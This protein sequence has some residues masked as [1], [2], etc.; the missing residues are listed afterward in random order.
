[1]LERRAARDGRLIDGLELRERA[2]A[3]HA[4]I[5]DRFTLSRRLLRS[6]SRGTWRNMIERVNVVSTGMAL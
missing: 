4:H 1:M 3:L 2:L 5:P 6:D